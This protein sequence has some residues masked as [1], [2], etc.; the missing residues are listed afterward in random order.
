[1]S[2]CGTIIRR[3]Y[4]W[5]RQSQ[6]TLSTLCRIEA[7]ERCADWKDEGANTCT[8]TRDEGYQAC[9]RQEDQGHR[10]CCDWWPCSWACDAW[11]WISHLVCV[12]WTWISNIVCVVWTWISK[13]VCRIVYWIWTTVCR[14]VVSI[15]SW[16]IRRVLT[17]IVTIPCQL[18]DPALDPRIRHIFVLVLENR[19]F[20]HMLGA[21]PIRGRDAETG[22]PTQTR[23]R[24]DDAF[25]DVRDSSGAVTHHCV[26]G[27]G[28][29]RSVGTDPGH[30]FGNTLLA[31]CGL[32]PD[33]TPPAYPPYPGTIDNSGYAQNFA[34]AHPGDPGTIMLSY[35]EQ[36]VPVLTALARE[37][38][39]CDNW[40]SSMPGPT[41]PNR[42]FYHAASSAGL[43]DSPGGFDSGLTELLSGL[44]FDNGTVYDLLDSENIDW[45]VYHGDAFPQVMSLAG[46]DLLTMQTRFHD[47]DDFEED[48]ADGSIANFVFLEPD[49]GD[50]ITGNTYRCG[51]S[52][53]PLDDITHG[54]RL[55][56]R[57]YEA[58]RGSDLWGQSMLVVAYDEGGGFFDHV[59]PGR[60][61]PPGDSVTDPVN[62][63]HGFDFSQL[64]TRIPAV[65][66]S[67]WIPRNVIDHRPYEHASVPA[68]V[69]RLW[70]LPAMTGRDAHVR[71]LADLLTLAAPRTDAPETLPDAAPPDVECPGDDDTP[72]PPD[73]DRRHRA[74]L[75]DT[76]TLARAAQADPAAITS[77]T[78][79]FLDVA[80]RR[81][82]LLAPPTER[83]PIFEQVRGFRTMGEA[84]LYVRAVR[85]ET[86]RPV[87]TP[88]PRRR[89]RRRPLSRYGD[90]AR[91]R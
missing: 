67:P 43:D 88:G 31:L 5:E 62:D 18:G 28:Q 76:V 57:V 84:A 13:W 6:I 58:I 91:G 83:R 75:F 33:G 44:V 59:P 50:D 1:M 63:H 34:D 80:L 70:G 8:Q 85:T 87:G 25:N 23:R 73:A 86:A 53:H 82:L 89:F 66:C 27:T 17:W 60:T 90:P 16:F 68:T 7:L 32:G 36:D 4:W 71:S 45:A 39:V 40:F 72:P 29:K 38:A 2:L 48:L 79:A 22:A 19:S 49:Y 12:A 41:W 61:V 30:E 35:T 77:T 9:T 47:M 65:V 21:T 81:D 37:F 69:E 3:L 20:D 74:T 54:E 26:V 11:V 46:M 52:Q 42:Y 24:P 14:I 56:K 78:R 15:I 55:I 10:D 51:A 64:G